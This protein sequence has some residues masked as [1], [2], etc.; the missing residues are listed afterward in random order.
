MAS[1][2]NTPVSSIAMALAGKSASVDIPKPTVGEVDSV[3]RSGSKKGLPTPPNSISPTLPPH[4][5]RKNEH[6]PLTPPG[7]VS[8]SDIDLQDAVEHAQAQSFRGFNKSVVDA[9]GNITPALLATHHLPEILLEHGPLAIRHIMGYLTTSVPGFS[10]IPPN[11]ARRIV[12]AALEGRSAHSD[13]VRESQGEIVFEKVGCGRWE[14]RRRGQPSQRSR[15]TSPVAARHAN[16]LRS[17]S[18]YSTSHPRS[19]YSTSHS[20]SIRLAHRPRNR[21]SS[22]TSLSRSHPSRLH[23]TEAD[24]MSLGNESTP[25][26]SEAEEP[27]PE[28]DIGEVT[29]EEDWASIGA[30]ALRAGFSFPKPTSSKG[31]YDYNA[32]VQR[33]SSQVRNPKRSGGGPA[34]STLAKSVPVLSDAEMKE[35]MTGVGKDESEAVKALLQL[36]SM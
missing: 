34:S 4:A 6:E 2:K 9:T 36:G 3:A 10:G 5:F 32:R 33:D 13:S 21:L 14:A 30:A 20:K 7:Q 35:F 17:P 25:S 31:R 15:H 8:D 27:Y 16:S 24:N 22:A 18:P 19:P 28:D 29:D 12:V 23:E 11:K 26:S 1:I